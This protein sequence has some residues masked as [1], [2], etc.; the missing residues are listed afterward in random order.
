M[1]IQI[2]I[3]QRVGGT[4][5]GGGSGGP[6]SSSLPSGRLA[7]KSGHVRMFVDVLRA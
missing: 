2:H 5:G 1:T 6:R 4:R 3:A 7:D